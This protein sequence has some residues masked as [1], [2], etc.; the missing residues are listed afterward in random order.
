MHGRDAGQKALHTLWSVGD[1]RRMV[2]DKRVNARLQ[3]RKT[4]REERSKL[5]KICQRRSEAKEKKDEGTE[6]M[7]IKSHFDREIFDL[8]KFICRTVYIFCKKGKMLKHL[9]KL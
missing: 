6:R 3:C 2:R 4:G 7:L 8:I 9:S 5:I 1:G